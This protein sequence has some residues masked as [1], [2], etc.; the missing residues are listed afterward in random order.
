MK[1]K[2]EL[3][4]RAKTKRTG[5][6]KYSVVEINVPPHDTDV[7]LIL[8]NGKVVSLQWRVETPSLDVCLPEEEHLV[9]CW[10]GNDMEPAPAFK[11]ARHSKAEQ[12]HFKDGH[13]RRCGQLVIDFSPNYLD[14][15]EEDTDES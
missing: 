13:V 8:R 14:L 6:Y 3:V 12:K 10:R 4:K 7:E 5:C 11:W 2:H 15:P 9:T 1:T